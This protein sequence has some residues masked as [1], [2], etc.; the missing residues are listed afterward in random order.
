MI[1]FFE[2]WEFGQVRR[3]VIWKGYAM[4]RWMSELFVRLEE[5]GVGGFM[6]CWRKGLES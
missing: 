4:V 2:E 5:R 3:G 1:H 6:I